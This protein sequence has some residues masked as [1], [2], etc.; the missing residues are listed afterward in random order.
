MLPP[1][2]NSELP[3]V[4]GEF[5]KGKLSNSQ[6]VSDIEDVNNNN[7]WITGELEHYDLCIVFPGEKQ[8]DTGEWDVSDRNH[9][10]INTIRHLGFDIIGFRV[11]GQKPKT[12]KER[13]CSK[14]SGQ[15]ESFDDY[16][17]IYVLLRAPLK[18]LREYADRLEFKLMLDPERAEKQLAQGD[19]ESGIAGVVIRHEPDIT[20]L[21]P[22]QFI[23]G[24]FDPLCEDL[25]FRPKEYQ[26]C[27]YKSA[28]EKTYR[29]E[30]KLDHPFR[31]LVRLKLSTMMLQ[32]RPRILLEDGQRVSRENLKIDRYQ[33]K[34]YI[35]G[36]FVLH[37]TKKNIA[38]REQWQKY[39]F[40]PLPREEI[41]EYFGEKMAFYQTFMDHYT[42]WLWIPALVAIPFQIAVFYYWD[43]S[44]S[45]IPFYALMLPI[46]LIFTVEVSNYHFELFC[47]FLSF[48]I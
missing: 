7:N 21:K 26:I 44:A 28:S 2:E 3:V 43:F 48:Y 15:E 29:E 6:P 8:A 46:W 30:T 20:P 36:C 25:Y 24:K 47:F 33:K 5:E 14:K 19:P 27:E 16:C 41:K 23:Y 18:K 31:D 17:L 10:Y 32:S 34:G 13:L 37:N 11:I 22:F 4:E 39:P 35:L 40:K 1:T 12:L 9:G 38:F 42:R 45:W